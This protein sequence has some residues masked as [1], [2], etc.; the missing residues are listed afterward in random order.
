MFSTIKLKLLKG[1]RACDLL[2]EAEYYRCVILS[3]ITSQ[4]TA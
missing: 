3:N 1:N 4:Q 2:A